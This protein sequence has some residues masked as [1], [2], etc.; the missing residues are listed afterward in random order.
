MESLDEFIEFIRRNQGISRKREIQAS[1]LLEQDLGITGD[2]G[3]DLL[4]AI[5][6]RY[7]LSFIG[8][9][10]TIRS[11]FGL[12][13]DQ[14]LF[15]SE[16]NLFQFLGSLFGGSLDPTKVKSISVGELYRATADA[17]ARSS[18]SSTS[19]TPNDRPGNA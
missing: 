8:H 2:D 4:D 5:Q 11:V 9:D 6:K 16:P 3:D 7:G 13:P 17:Y 10:G 19:N 12:G 18:K 15:H 14:F 1:S